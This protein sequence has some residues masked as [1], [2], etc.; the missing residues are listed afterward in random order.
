MLLSFACIFRDEKRTHA[1]GSEDAER[2]SASERE[3]ERRN[4]RRKTEMRCVCNKIFI[5]SYTTKALMLISFI[6]V[7]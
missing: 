6:F 5:V 7:S 4:L 3:R 1:K 2:V